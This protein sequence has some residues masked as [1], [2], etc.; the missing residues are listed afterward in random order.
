MDHLAQAHGLGRTGVGGVVNPESATARLTSSCGQEE[1]GQSNLQSLLRVRESFARFQPP[2]KR[3]GSLEQE[4][5][6]EEL[7]IGI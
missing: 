1:P 7:E 5:Q 2:A 6:K 4:P 3:R